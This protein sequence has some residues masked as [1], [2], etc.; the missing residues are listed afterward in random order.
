MALSEADTRSKLI[1]PKLYKCGW[2]EEHIKREET[3]GT[4]IIAGAN[5]KRRRGTTDYTLRIKI[6]DGSQPVA[7]AVIEAKADKYAPDEGLEQ[8]KLYGAAKRLNVQFVFSTNGHQFVEFNR[9]TQITSAPRPLDEFP[10]PAELR[11]RYEQ[12]MGFSLASDAAR[13]L[14]QHYYNGEGGR[15][16]YQDAA[17]RA[18]FEK[19]ATGKKRALLSLATGAG[20]TFIAVNLLR[21]IDSAGQLKKALFICDRDELRTQAGVAFQKAFGD[22]A[23][24]VSSGKPQKTAKVLIATYQT[25]D[26][27]TEVADANFLTKNYPENYFSHIVIDE[28]HRSA[29]GKWRQVFDRN[30]D[31]V[32]IG[33]T[34]T[35]RKIELPEDDEEARTDAEIM[36]DNYRHFGDPVYEYDLTQGIEDG[37]LAACEIVSRDILINERK[38]RE[39]Q[40]GLDKELDTAKLSDARTGIRMSREALRQ[41]YEAATLDAQLRL[42]DR[43]KAL[44]EDL[45]NQLLENG[46]TPEQKTII[47]CASDA[48]AQDIANALGNLYSEW[49]GRESRNIKDHYAFKCTSRSSG[50]D[51][52]PDFRGSN[53]SHFIATTVDLLTTGVD[54]PNVRN[55]VFFRYLKS[56]ILFYQMLGRGTR[57]DEGKLMFRAYDYTDA[58]RLL[59]REFV[60]ALTKERAKVEG[61]DGTD[62]DDDGGGDDE[63]KPMPQAVGIEFGVREVGRY[64]PLMVDGKHTKVSI[65]EYRRLLAEQLVKEAATLDVFRTRWIRPRERRAL[66]DNLVRAGLSPVQVQ[67]IGGMID[68][69]LYDVL[70]ELGYG[71]NPRKR[72]ERVHAFTYKHEEWLLSMP[73]EAQET[74]KAL[75]EPFVVGGTDE[76]ENPNVLQMPA[77]SR[78]GGMRALA[79][80][81]RPPVEILEE[82]KARLFSA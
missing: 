4:I 60:S 21:R 5:G 34:A 69:D 50:N 24:E 12:Q 71:I 48:H 15:R 39:A 14:L 42:P 41:K 30:P 81:G 82:A 78:A 57:L 67:K 8:A 64:V 33:L 2:T 61:P 52:L 70:A 26:V 22:N 35:P 68:Y 62:D 53:N 28:C 65:E 76:L 44:S 80:T 36:R 49:C 74:I 20:K 54:V 43:V 27:D 7:V 55:I 3:A 40:K 77:V 18:V 58:T 75:I 31:A 11:A 47:F 72:Q 1:D 32:Q 45:F 17:I 66:I 19:L 16:Y 13:P 51:F 29:W 25:L 73:K 46:G 79:A 37:Y 63:A 23:A 56:P 6:D 59:G 10:S 9:K 38:E